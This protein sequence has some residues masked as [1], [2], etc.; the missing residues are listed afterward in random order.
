MILNNI[1]L[2]NQIRNCIKITKKE[3]KYNLPLIFLQKIHNLRKEINLKIKL[4][5][6]T[7]K[8]KVLKYRS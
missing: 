3:Q 2:I 5:R 1:F 4:K 7:N 8:V 6:S